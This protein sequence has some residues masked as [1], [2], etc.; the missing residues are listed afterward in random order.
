MPHRRKLRSAKL[1]YKCIQIPSLNSDHS[2]RIP[3]RI[4]QD[5]EVTGPCQ[6]WFRI[7][8]SILVLSLSQDPTKFNSESCFK[9]LHFPCY[10]IFQGQTGSYSGFLQVPFQIIL[11][12]DKSGQKKWAPNSVNSKFVVHLRISILQN[13]SLNYWIIL[14]SFYPKAEQLCSVLGI[15]LPDNEYFCSVLGTALPGSEYVFSV[16]GMIF[17][18]VW[19]TYSARE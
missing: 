7:L 1:L 18:V 8:F 10:R 6:V 13:S 14:K 5:P 17:P 11:L 4:C 9:S 15:I 3:G 2:L 16:L 19:Q 12:T